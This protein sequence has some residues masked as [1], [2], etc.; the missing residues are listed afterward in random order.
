MVES[1]PFGRLTKG[2]SPRL[3]ILRHTQVKQIISLQLQHSGQLLS[4]RIVKFHRLFRKL[5]K[6]PFQIHIYLS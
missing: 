3:D 2:I 6:L 1:P 4:L 5:M